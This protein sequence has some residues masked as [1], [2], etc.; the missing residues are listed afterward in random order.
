[1]ILLAARF[2]ALADEHGPRLYL[3][4]GPVLIGLGTLALHVRRA[5]SD[6]WTVGIAALA[7]FSLGLAMLVAPITATALKSAPR[8]LAGI[9][10]GVNSTVSRLGSLIAIAVIGLVIT[11]VFDGRTRRA[12]RRP[13]REAT[14]RRRSSAMPRSTRSGPGMVFAAALA[15]AGAAVGAVGISNREARGEAEG[16]AN[17]RRRQ[18]EVERRGALAAARDGLL[19]RLADPV[20]NRQ[21]VALGVVQ[22]PAPRGEARPDEQLDGRARGREPPR[23][24]RPRRPAVT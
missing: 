17:R 10:S 8:A 14:R 24:R 22:R 18:P 4:L 6:F 11:L 9:A 12:G 7:L 15:F 20:E 13:A 1:M 19:P 2:G 3:T 16:S 23:R 21:P 5:T